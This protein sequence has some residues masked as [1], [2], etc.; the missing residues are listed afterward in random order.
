MAGPQQGTVRFQQSDSALMFRAEG[1]GTMTHGLPMRQ[2]AER[3][4][5]NG[6]NTIFVDLRACT[7]MDST[8]LGTLMN[9][10]KMLD[11]LPDGQ[12]RLITPST[13]CSRI[14]HQMGV[15]DLL[16]AQEELPA[17][18]DKW[19]DLP[20]QQDEPQFRRHALQ[21]HEVL[22]ELPGPAGERFRQVVRCMNDAEKKSTPPPE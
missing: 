8:F 15:G 20:S 21:A 16:L 10:K 3:A 9:L 1:R 22:A 7:Y 6:T 17:D 12:F 4:L 14:L 5:S 18:P 2:L 11:K 13:A 19:A